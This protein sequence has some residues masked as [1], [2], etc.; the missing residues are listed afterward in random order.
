MSDKLAD[1]LRAEFGTALQDVRASL[2]QNPNGP[3]GAFGKLPA[4]NVEALVLHHTAGSYDTT[5]ENIAA[6]HVNTRQFAGIGYHI[7]IQNGRV[8]YMGDIGTARAH[9]AGQNHRYVGIV[10]AG[11]YQTDQPRAAD[12]DVLRRLGPVL[13]RYFGRPLP[14]R[15]HRDVAPAGYTVCPGVNLHR[16]MP[17]LDNGSTPTPG[18]DLAKL[19]AA[20][21]AEHA[22]HGIR[23]NPDAAIARAMRQDGVWPTTNEFDAEGVV[24]QRA[25]GPTGAWVYWWSEGRVSKA[26]V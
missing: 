3:N 20:A 5:W 15:G 22:A 9:V 24:A 11:N 13:R 4:A 12:L 2:P 23:Y 18:P 17:V 10:V 7:G 14:W 26:K 25:E 16:L 19:R 6:Y 21:E 1:M 8:Y